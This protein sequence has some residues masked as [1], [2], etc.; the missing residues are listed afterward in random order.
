M[1]GVAA[2]PTELEIVHE[3]LELFKIPWEPAV[4]GRKYRAV[5]STVG[6]PRDFDADLIVIF[7]SRPCSTESAAGVGV[8]ERA[9]A[10]RCE[11]NGRGFPLYGRAATFAGGGP[12]I[13]TCGREALD[14]RTR[15]NG[16]QVWRVGYDLLEEVRC[17]LTSGQSAAWALS[18]T[19]EIH[20]AILRQLLTA[21][22]VSFIEVPPRP[23]GRRFICCLTHDLDFFGIRRHR[24]DRTLAGF[25]VRATVGT[26]AD[27]LRGRRSIGEAVRNWRAAISLPFV[28]LG[29]A[30]DPWQP[31]EDYAVADGDRPA[32]FFV[33]P[34]RGHPGIAPG[35]EV[36]QTRAVKYQASDV[37]QEMESVLSRGG[38]LAVHG[39]DG[40]RDEGAG[41]NELAK[42]SALIGGRTYR[43]QD[44]LAAFRGRFT[45]P[46]RGRG[47]RLR[48]DL[49]IQ[50]CR[51]VPGGDQPGLPAGRRESVAGASARDHGH[52]LVLSGTNGTSPRGWPRPVPVRRRTTCANSGVR[53]S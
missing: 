9:D 33:V 51:R 30:A 13:L 41:R 47:V 31:I 24:F 25:L 12:S 4:A 20:I 8:G 40:W 3:F 35:G 48:L 6:P 39:I 37:R 10:G 14:Y 52:R 26:L 49:R 27:L 23:A 53:W 22:G 42:V 50:R 17:L 21:S 43:C 29:L 5:L 11:W 2:H 18:P 36:N 28:F 32:T 19:L 7:G 44:A 15:Q 45:G 34:F 16:R 38:E 46:P 1:I